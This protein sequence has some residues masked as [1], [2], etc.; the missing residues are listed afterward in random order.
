M[1]LRTCESRSDVAT[2]ALV[3]D[4]PKFDHASDRERWYPEAACM[5]GIHYPNSP[6]RQF[7]GDQRRR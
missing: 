5:E 4:G 1:R 7:V 3:L 2:I 6:G